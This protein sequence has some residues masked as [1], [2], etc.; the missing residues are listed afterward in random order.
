MD[1]SVLSV[2][3]FACTVF[4]TRNVVI[5]SGFL[6]LPY[7]RV[8]MSCKISEIWQLLYTVRFYVSWCLL[9]CNLVFL[10][11][12]CYPLIIDVFPMILVCYQDL[13]LLNRHM[14]ISKR[15]TTFA[16]IFVDC[17]GCLGF[18]ISN[19]ASTTW[20]DK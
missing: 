9:F 8:T 5:L 11:F 15:Y 14:T 16:F 6:T 7:K 18:F 2:L 20:I 10:L 17:K 12:R 4:L 1:L 13:F 3:V 19:K